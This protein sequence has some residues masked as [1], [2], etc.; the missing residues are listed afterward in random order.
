MHT[1]VN[2]SFTIEKWGVRGSSLHGHVIMM[3][4]LSIVKR[5]ACAVWYVICAFGFHISNVRV[6]HDAAQIT[7]FESS[8]ATANFY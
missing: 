8:V 1:P 4:Y 3:N 2:P 7:N 6:S 5:S